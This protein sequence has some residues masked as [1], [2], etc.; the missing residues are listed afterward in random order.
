MT[1]TVEF[2]G[3]DFGLPER[4]NERNL[5]RLARH[6]RAGATSDSMAAMAAVDELLDQLVL[7]ADT[8]RFDALCDEHKASAADLMEFVG[9]AMGVLAERPTAR[10]SVSSAG[11]SAIPASSASPLA[12][13]ASAPSSGP[14]S[15]PNLTPAME[16]A[17]TR[18]EGR[19]DIQAGMLAQFESDLLSV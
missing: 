14:S 5:L 17:L 9:K 8:A 1:G 10:P 7:P 3:Q 12:V 6:A 18:F 16:R 15:E 13:P 19:P 11:Q 2:Y 4:I